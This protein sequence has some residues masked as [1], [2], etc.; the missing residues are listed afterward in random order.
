MK[1]HEIQ[2]AAS[3]NGKDQILQ[4]D[5]KRFRVH[6]LDLCGSLI[7]ELPG[8]RLALVHATARTF[9]LLYFES[10]PFWANDQLGTSCGTIILIPSSLNAA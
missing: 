2:A 5:A 1:W 8:Q 6:A 3:M 9:V 7:L 4:Y 10:L